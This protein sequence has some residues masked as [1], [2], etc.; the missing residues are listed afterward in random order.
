MFDAR[1]TL[2]LDRVMGV[3]LRFLRAYRAV[4]GRIT[5]EQNVNRRV[6]HS[7][8]RTG[9]AARSATTISTKRTASV[10]MPLEAGSAV[11]IMTVALLAGPGSARAQS[12][13]E[14]AKA[15][16]PLAPVTAINLHDYY[17]PTLYGVPEQS[18]NTMMVRGVFATSRMILRA[19][20]PLATVPAGTG[21]PVSGLGDLNVFD[22]F[23][24]TGSEA[25]TQFGIGPLLVVPTA[26][27]D[28]LGAGKWQ[29]GGAV[30]AVSNVTPAMLAFA[31][32]TYQHSFA[33]DDARPTTSVLV[34]QPGA[35]WQVGGG[36]YLRTS[37]VWQFNTETGDYSIPIGLGAGKVMRAGSAV[38]NFFL[39]PQ[40]TV[41]HDGVGQPAFQLF[42]GIMAQFPKK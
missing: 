31:L 20:L 26:T 2:A 25:K 17:V 42:T 34:V 14:V 38:L 1:T 3:G 24:L 22:A 19:T 37:G 13:A 39:E 30:V 12:A 27:D 29:A 7:L 16:N 4:P 8:R 18:A 21:D 32:V 36:Y 5:F 40:F 33:G 28:Q 10:R 6:R 41:L 9:R 11:C 15:N 23:L 35:V